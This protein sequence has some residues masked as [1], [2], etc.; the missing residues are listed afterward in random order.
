MAFLTFP[1][2][3]WSSAVLQLSHVAV[4]LSIHPPQPVID[5]AEHTATNKVKIV[6]MA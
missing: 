4:L 6:K 3:P 1:A 2:T 5:A